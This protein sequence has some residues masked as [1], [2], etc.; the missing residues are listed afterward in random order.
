[1]AKDGSLSFRLDLD[2][3]RRFSAFK[4]QH[5]M[6]KTDAAIELIT[7]G[8]DQTALLKE[9]VHQHEVTR[10]ELERLVALVAGNSGRPLEEE[11]LI[12]AIKK[13]A[14]RNE[15]PLFEKERD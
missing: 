14:A 5:G 3:Y 13:I 1:M 4:E 9:V 8:L 7:R 12:P 2:L 6:S 15:P 10:R 11:V